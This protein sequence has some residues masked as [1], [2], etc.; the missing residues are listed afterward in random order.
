MPRCLRLA[1]ILLLFITLRSN[2]DDGTVKVFVLAGQSNMQG[3][4]EIAADPRRN[5]GKGTLEHLVKD[6]ATRERFAHL[7]DEDGQWVARD[8]VSIAYLDRRGKLTVG[9]GATEKVIGPELQ[10]G[11]IVGDHFDEPVLLLKAAW[12]GKS[13]A[14]DFRSPSAGPLPESFGENLLKKA[15]EEPELVGRYYREMLAHV[16]S[17][18]EKMGEQFP[19]LRDRKPEIVGLGWHQ[20][21]NDRVNQSFNDAYEE[22]LTHFVKDVRRELGNER[23][24]FVIA[25][26]GMHGPEEKHPRA[27]S[28]MRAQAAVAKRAEFHG[29]VGFV[30]TRSFYRPPE[31]SPS[32]QGFHWNRNAETYFLIGDGMGRKMIELI[33]ARDEE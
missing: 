9:Y 2:A 14:V 29:T 31:E 1:S 25:E 8:D 11:H 24:P 4:G 5:G 13:V 26:T 12:G 16:R 33:E 10:F 30:P 3:A 7:V 21:W 17:S 27:A 6:P 22:N 28:L 15:K 20:G 19:E 23:L 18:L 32:R